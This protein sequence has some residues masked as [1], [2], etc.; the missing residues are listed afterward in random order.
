MSATSESSAVPD[1]SAV[2]KPV[3]QVGIG[4]PVYNGQRYVREAIDT[5]LA[6]TYTDFTLYVS[7]N[8]STDDTQSIC[9][10]YA[11]RDSRVVYHREPNNRGAAWNYNKVREMSVSEPFFKWM[12]DDDVHDPTY[13]EVCMEALDQ[14]PDAVAAAPRS[15][16]IDGDGREVLRDFR[17]VPWDDPTSPSTRLRGV[18]LYPHDDAFAFAVMR[19]DAVTPLS[20]FVAMENADGVMQAEL[21]LQGPFVHVN[22][23]LFGNRLHTRRSTAATKAKSRV[24]E[25]EQWAAWWGVSARKD[26]PA[27]LTLK[28]FTAAINAS[29]VKGVERARC[30]KVVSIYGARRAPAYLGDAKRW[31][32]RQRAEKSA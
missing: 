24:E 21:I 22:K 23:H 1:K 17:H 6:Q 31:I 5:I 19:R 11:S 20:P 3:A 13:L 32:Q 8:G 29:N 14:R 25:L 10:D 30:L 12:A 7:D 26:P 27:A 15:R 4:L 18:M 9:E 2:T 16:F 28:A